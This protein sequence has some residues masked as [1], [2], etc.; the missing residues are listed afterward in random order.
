MPSS[1]PDG[2]TGKNRLA[3][4]LLVTEP[5][6]TLYS[7][8]FNRRFASFPERM[9]LDAARAAARILDAGLSP[10][11]QGKM[12][13]DCL[14]NLADINEMGGPRAVLAWC[15]TLS[16]CGPFLGCSESVAILSGVA[17]WL[18]TS[19]GRDGRKASSYREAALVRGAEALRDPFILGVIDAARRGNADL[20]EELTVSLAVMFSA[21]AARWG[22][23]RAQN[24]A[25]SISRL[26]LDGPDF[27]I[28]ALEISCSSGQ[29][30]DKLVSSL[31]KDGSLLW[32]V[33][34]VD[35]SVLDNLV[36]RP[37]S[38]VNAILM[39]E[40]FPGDMSM[41]IIERKES[42]GNLS[43]IV[44][45]LALGHPD[46]GVR[47]AAMGR[48]MDAATDADHSTGLRLFCISSLTAAAPEIAKQGLL[49]LRRVV[50]DE[51]E[52]FVLRRSAALLLLGAY[53][54]REEL[55]PIAEKKNFLSLKLLA[56]KSLLSGRSFTAD[57]KRAYKSR[58]LET[59]LT[60]SLFDKSVA[61]RIAKKIIKEAGKRDEH[62]K[63]GNPFPFMTNLRR[64]EAVALFSGQDDA[65]ADHYLELLYSAWVSNRAVAKDAIAEVAKLLKDPDFIKAVA[66]SAS[67]L[68]N[69]IEGHLVNNARIYGYAAA[70]E[71]A[72][73][74]CSLADKPAV[75]EALASCPPSLM[76]SSTGEELDHA[77]ATAM[78]NLRC[79]EFA[80]AI[81][82]YEGDTALHIVRE[83]YNLAL[84]C[85][86]KEVIASSSSALALFRGHDSLAK[87]VAGAFK[88]L[89][90]VPAYEYRDGPEPAHR[91]AVQLN[92]DAS[93]M[94]AARFLSEPRVMKYLITRQG[95]IGAGKAFSRSP[96]GFVVDL[97][98][99]WHAISFPQAL[100]AIA[101]HRGEGAA[102]ETLI[103]LESF[104]SSKASSLVLDR[105]ATL[106]INTNRPESFIEAERALRHP[107]IVDALEQAPGDGI[108]FDY[109]VE[110]VLEQGLAAGI[111]AAVKNST[112]K[113]A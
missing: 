40:G 43:A 18:G 3:H 101:A 6:E 93:I 77:V 105:S 9:R 76:E 86:N 63:D 94:R 47:L 32:A 99:P 15:R 107:V 103:T 42:M 12:A 58:L 22:A 46:Q 95:I 39:R 92:G 69:Q 83:F 8:L 102:M 51:N 91:N 112:R 85:E 54:L 57:Q 68:R 65:T 82:H 28:P 79:V 62:L 27:L 73:T 61:A 110:I 111:K 75:A 36:R 7:V 49:R 25:R 97:L 23:G 55:V 66:T 56:A 34:K 80:E 24:V 10:G 48:L 98:K 96:H 81:R 106:A 31:E 26:D 20:S 35:R 38:I 13:E 87:Q 84:H 50:A 1:T 59:A 104:R 113:T 78:V 33:P 29:E 44:D 53:S 5:V 90:M 64:D 4:R 41:T 109:L 17:G 70:V 19:V 30:L 67:R 60:I 2:R 16:E 14:E 21:I 37:A 52:M 108:I 11:E 88:S 74:V 100:A 72:R 71:A 45:S 89:L